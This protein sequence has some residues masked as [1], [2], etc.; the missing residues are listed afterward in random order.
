MFDADRF[1]DERL[2]SHQRATGT[3][4][5]GR[6]NSVSLS[7]SVALSTLVDGR[8]AGH[9]GEEEVLLVQW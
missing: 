9:V 2:P 5:E 3:P 7:Q 4:G 6:P 1:P 8:L